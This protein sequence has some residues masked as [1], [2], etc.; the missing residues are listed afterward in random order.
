MSKDS[1]QVFLDAFNIKKDDLYQW[2]SQ[3]VAVPF[4]CAE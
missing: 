4:L 3:D 2:G 1:Y